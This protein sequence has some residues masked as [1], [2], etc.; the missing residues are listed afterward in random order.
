MKKSSQTKQRPSEPSSRAASQ[1]GQVQGAVTPEG[2]QPSCNS[3]NHGLRKSVT[4]TP[5]ATGTWRLEPRVQRREDAAANWAN[6]SH[7]D[8]MTMAPANPLTNNR[9]RPTLARYMRRFELSGD[10]AL[11]EFGALRAERLPRISQTNPRNLPK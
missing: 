10:R 1:R 9:T 4:A 3:Q 6:L 2:K 7:V 5:A 11:R 8:R